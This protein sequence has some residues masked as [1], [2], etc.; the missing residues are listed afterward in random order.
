[1]YVMY[2]MC[3]CVYVCMY[4]Y[5]IHAS[6]V[7]IYIDK[8][9][10]ALFLSHR[11]IRLLNVLLSCFTLTAVNFNVL[12]TFNLAQENVCTYC[13]GVEGNTRW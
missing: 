2:V 1:M 9:Y 4:A 3:V 12:L 13:C 6:I 10:A 5:I 7:Q 8:S 11:P